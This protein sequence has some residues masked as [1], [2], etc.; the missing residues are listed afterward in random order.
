MMLQHFEVKLTLLLQCARLMTHILGGAVI[1]S[2]ASQQETFI[3]TSWV[4]P[5]SVVFAC[6]LF[7]FCICF[8]T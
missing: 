1:S 5:F 2:V 4:G 7:S 8:N 6:F 3:S